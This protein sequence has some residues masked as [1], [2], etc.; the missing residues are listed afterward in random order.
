M[1]WVDMGF[2]EQAVDLKEKKILKKYI[3]IQLHIYL[4][5]IFNFN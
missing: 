2:G 3:I 1:G 5:Y 4:A